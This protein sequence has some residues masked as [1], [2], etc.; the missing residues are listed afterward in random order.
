MCGDGARACD[1]V[2]MRD[3]DLL[4]GLGAIAWASA[5]LAVPA[6]AQLAEIVDPK[7]A[8]VFAVAALGRWYAR[9]RKG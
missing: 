1:A 6:L 9:K 5:A 4:A 8:A 3:V 2:G 7:A